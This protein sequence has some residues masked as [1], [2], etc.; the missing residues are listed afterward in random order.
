MSGKADA[1]LAAAR[2]EAVKM[3]AQKLLQ[4]A[5]GEGRTE[6]A[7]EAL[8]REALLKLGMA[9]RAARHLRSARLPNVPASFASCQTCSTAPPTCPRRRARCDRHPAPAAGAAG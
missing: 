5:A 7:E 6:E 1:V 4:A 8:G 9:V 3:G 2:R